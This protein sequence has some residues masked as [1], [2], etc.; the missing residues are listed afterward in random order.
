LNVAPSHCAVPNAGMVA[1]GNIAEHNRCLGEVN[2]LAEAG[3]ATKVALEEWQH[4]GHGSGVNLRQM[5]SNK[6]TRRLLRSRI[7]GGLPNLFL[8]LWSEPEAAPSNRWT[9]SPT[10]Y[11][12]ICQKCVCVPS[13]SIRAVFVGFLAFPD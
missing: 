7:H 9:K 11:S 5:V 10:I 1:H 6:K 12:R 8:L 2:T 4:V 3:L 13:G